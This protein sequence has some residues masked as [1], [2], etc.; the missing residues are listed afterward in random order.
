MD[1]KEAAALLGCPVFEVRAVADGVIT[2][3]DGSQHEVPAGQVAHWVRTNPTQT[4]PRYRAVLVEDEPSEDDEDAGP[5]V[6]T[7][8]D[9]VPEGTALQILEWVGTDKDRAA[10]ALDVEA[11][12]GDSTRKSLVA[13]LEKLA[14]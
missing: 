14:G 10:K 13:A 6:D 5:A 1:R 4:P 12:K 8:G 9:G 11:A 2:T 3:R 7:D